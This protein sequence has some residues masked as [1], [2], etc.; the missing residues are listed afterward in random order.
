MNYGSI[1]EEK[2]DTAPGQK[3]CSVNVNLQNDCSDY[4]NDEEKQILLSQHERTVESSSSPSMTSLKSIMI[5]RSCLVFVAF[6]YG[7]L[8]VTLRMLYG[9]PNPPSAPALS[10]SRGWMASIAFLPYCAISLSKEAIRRLNK[11]NSST[12]IEAKRTSQKTSKSVPLWV[13]ALELAFWNFCAQGLQNVGLLYIESARAAFLTQMS[14]VFTPIISVIAGCQVKRIVWCG[15]LVALCGLIVLSSSSSSSSNADVD[16][17]E[18]SSSFSLGKGDFFILS[19]ALCWSMYLYRTS[20]VGDKYPE[21]PLQAVKTVLLAC[22]Y[23]SWLLVVSLQSYHSYQNNLIDEEDTPVTFMD[24][25]QNQ[26]LGWD[27]NIAVTYTILAYSA[28]GPGA[29]ADVIQQVG[30]KYVSASEANV[31]LSLEP[32]FTAT[33]ASFMLSEVMTSKES[34]GGGLIFLAA[35]LASS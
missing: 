8:N 34:L 24:A 16:L 25:L 22:F 29:L 32:V 3:N 13:I 30:Q 19:G 10:T 23:T 35:L 18:E 5:G 7:T 31:I 17:T 27:Q 21:V 4:C 20:I 33:C 26:W 11:N 9:L 1:D 6:L 28:F 15:C 12:S 2:N 14:V